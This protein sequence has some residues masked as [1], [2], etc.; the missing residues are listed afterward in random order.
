[1]YIFIYIYIYQLYHQYITIILAFHR[2]NILHRRPRLH[3]LLQLGWE[4]SLVILKITQ[5][6]SGVSKIP[7]DSRCGT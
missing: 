3:Q 6:F 7:K 2:S 1:M 4:G 5:R